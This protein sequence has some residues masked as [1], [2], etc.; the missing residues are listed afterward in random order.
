[1]AS[2]TGPVCEKHVPQQSTRSRKA[3]KEIFEESKEPSFAKPQ[4]RGHRRQSAL[5]KLV[6]MAGSR[7]VDSLASWEETSQDRIERGLNPLAL[8]SVEM[9]Y[10]QA[11]LR[12]SFGAEA[13]S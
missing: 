8:P 7:M 1:M 3:S 5:Q 6:S 9:Q 12:R 4:A 11:E 10:E 2:A 13:R